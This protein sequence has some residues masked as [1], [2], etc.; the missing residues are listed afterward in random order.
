MNSPQRPGSEAL[1]I[2]LVENS[3]RFAAFLKDFIS[4]IPRARVVEIVRSGEEALAYLRTHEPQLVLMDLGLPGING[5]EAT[6]RIK[7]QSGAPRVFM[8]TTHDAPEY[9]AS[10][11]EAGAD[12]YVLKSELV[13]EL[14]GLI[15]RLQ[16]SPKT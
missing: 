9:R 5:I 1:D 10:A 4:R 2:L 6:R 13:A 14:P 16:L 3:V 11:A 7:S 15:E 8:L 12:G